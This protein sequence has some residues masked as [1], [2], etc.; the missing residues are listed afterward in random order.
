MLGRLSSVFDSVVERTK[1]LFSSDKLKNSD[2]IRPSL[3]VGIRGNIG[4]RVQD[5]LGKETSQDR[6]LDSWANGNGWNLNPG[7]LDGVRLEMPRVTNG[8]LDVFT[9][10]AVKDE[11]PGRLDDI[12]FDSIVVAKDN[13][14]LDV[15]RSQKKT[16]GLF[17]LSLKTAELELAETARPSFN[18]GVLGD[19]IHWGVNDDIESPNSNVY[20]LK[21]TPSPQEVREISPPMRSGE[22]FVRE[23]AWAHR[24]RLA[25]AAAVLAAIGGIGQVKS[26]IAADEPTRTYSVDDIVPINNEQAS[27]I[28]AGRATREDFRIGGPNKMNQTVVRVDKVN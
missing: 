25:V 28:A 6:A 23:S 13:P 14:D 4:Q 21:R 11:T 27:E 20:P 17:A 7:K 2:E 16:Y 19:R 3:E 10:S 24:V 9:R 26:A 12:N 15:F 5:A 1:G 22:A 18:A 8:G